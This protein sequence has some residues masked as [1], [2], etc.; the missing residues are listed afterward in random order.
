MDIYCPHCGTRY[1]VSDEECGRKA[2][3]EVCNSKFIITASQRPISNAGQTSLQEDADTK[4]VPRPVFGRR[5]TSPVIRLDYARNKKY[6][7]STNTAGN[8]PVGIG[9][10]YGC[11]TSFLV[12]IFL[13]LEAE[14]VGFAFR[15][16]LLFGCI[17]GL[18]SY[19]IAKNMKKKADVITDAEIDAQAR[20]IG[21]GLEESALDKL[22]VDSDEVVMV[23]PLKFW[24]YRFACPSVLGDD[25]DNEAL[26][27]CGKEGK[28]RSSEVSHTIFFFGEHSVYCFERTASLVGP[29]SSD[30]TNEYFYNDIVSVKT[31]KVEAKGPKS[32]SHRTDAFV[33]T[34]TGGEKLVC[35]VENQEEAEF[36]VRAFRSLLKQKKL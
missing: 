10:G 19:V 31:E 9:V 22:G 6:F 2:L 21:N 24:G 1:E 14:L 32:A 35:E 20:A 7:S 26:W 3:C 4:K 13:V 27:V 5:V 29:V 16:A 23:K 12:F 17:F 34:N 28:Y 33:L 25:A 30:S 8:D 11:G 18:I 36:A 15:I